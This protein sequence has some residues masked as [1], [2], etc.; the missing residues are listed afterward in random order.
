MALPRVFERLL[1]VPRAVVVGAEVDVRSGEGS[2][3]RRVQRGR[4]FIAR[5]RAGIVAER[6]ERES[7]R[8]DR[9][10]V[11]RRRSRSAASKALRAGSHV[12]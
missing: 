9:F 2:V 5:H 12:S 7:E 10:D 3:A 8:V 1:G 11:R 6:L 4:L